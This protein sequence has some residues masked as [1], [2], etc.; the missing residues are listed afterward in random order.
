MDWL[1]DT[2]NTLFLD[3][4]DDVPRFVRDKWRGPALMLEFD[5]RRFDDIFTSDTCFCIELSQQNE[6]WG[7]GITYISVSR[8]GEHQKTQVNVLIEKI[9]EALQTRSNMDL[10]VWVVDWLNQD[11]SFIVVVR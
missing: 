3:W 4:A 2:N 9:N 7:A 8:R 6:K 1:P 10:T 11:P 5:C